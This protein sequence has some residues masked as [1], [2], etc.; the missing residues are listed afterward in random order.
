[1]RNRLIITT[2]HQLGNQIMQYALWSYLRQGGEDVS[3]YI[4]NEVLSKTFHKDAVNDPRALV[5][6]LV[7]H[8]GFF[9]FCNL[10]F[11]KVTGRPKHDYIQCLNYRIIPFPNW[12]SYT[13]FREFYTGGGLDLAFPAQEDARNSALIAEMESCNSVSLHVR[14]GDYIKSVYWR[15]ALGDICDLPYYAEAIAKVR[16]LLPDPKFYVFS[17]DPEWVRSNLVLDNAVYVTWNTGDRSFRDMELMSHCRANI[18]AN[19]TFSLCGALMNVHE[20]PIRIAPVKWQNTIRDR[21]KDKFLTPDWITIDNK[22]PQVSILC[23]EAL[24]DR[25]IRQLR[26]QRYTD[27]EVIGPSTVPGDPRFHAG[28]PAGRHRYRYEAQDRQAFRSPGHLSDWIAAIYQKEL[29]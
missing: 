4:Q 24:S 10:A 20:N 9:R 8:Q 19:S 21:Q 11:W 3:L 12:D 17:D 2:A 1:M 13:F 22:K 25:E 5:R 26:K 18:V 28:T 15:S 7:R 29:G 27:F 16:S 6:F 14:R 23:D